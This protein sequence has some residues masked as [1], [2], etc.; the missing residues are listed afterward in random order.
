MEKYL[1]HITELKLH[2]K[3]CWGFYFYQLWILWFLR[4]KIKHKC[5][6]WHIHY[7]LTIQKMG[8]WMNRKK[9]LNINCTMILHSANNISQ[10]TWKWR[11]TSPKSNAY[12]LTVCLFIF[13]QLEPFY[14]ERFPS[15]RFITVTAFRYIVYGIRFHKYLN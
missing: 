13:L 2:S 11:S 15:F 4:K 12:I 8:S 5:D 3:Y 10:M 9:I 7:V 1:H 14:Q 6:L